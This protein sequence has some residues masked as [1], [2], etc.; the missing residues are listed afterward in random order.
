MYYSRNCIQAQAI[1]MGQQ[2]FDQMLQPQ[3][4]AFDYSDIGADDEDDEGEQE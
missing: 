3:E 4:T 1:L 2:R